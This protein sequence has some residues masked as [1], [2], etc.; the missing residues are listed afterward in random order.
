M[1]EGMDE[2]AGVLGYV[3]SAGCSWGVQRTFLFS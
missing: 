2:G 3:T 1:D